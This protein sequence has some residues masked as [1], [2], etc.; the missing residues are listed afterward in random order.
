MK[1]V[2]IMPGVCVEKN[3]GV[4][5]YTMWK[6]V[7][8]EFEKR[9]I[10]FHTLDIYENWEELDWIICDNG[11]TTFEDYY[12]LERIWKRGQGKK[13]IYIAEEPEVVDIR[14]SLENIR[15]LLKIF[16]YITTWDLSIKD[17]RIF[18]L[19]IP[20][21]HFANIKMGKEF[22]DRK[23]MVN[24]SGNKSSDHPKELYGER[25]AFIE[26]CEKN[27]IDFAL[28]GTGWNLEER[29]SYK[30]CAKNKL[31]TY[32]DYKYAL[33][34]ENARDIP[35]YITE[36]IMDCFAG[37]I[38]P[39]YAGAKDISNIIPQKLYIDYFA[40]DSKE[41]L[42]K[43]LENISEEEY[44][45]KLSVTKKFIE[46]EGLYLFTAKGFVDNFINTFS[47]KPYIK[48]PENKLYLRVF[49]LN[50]LKKI[51]DSLK[52]KNISW[53]VKIYRKILGVKG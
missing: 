20:S 19:T 16:P 24:I 8:I 6:D 22:K 32:G 37:N 43:Y 50:R 41:E 52:L 44:N 27:S 9:N 10:E 45:E 23:F 17:S 28:Y 40:F 7:K 13:L 18:S 29:P 25:L 51:K 30:G 12:W 39:V 36:K 33:C 15:N 53:L 49:I 35:G 48:L 21:F 4:F 5:K 3:D 26:Y 11:Y 1:K 46:D 31:E 14:H 47:D 34:L 42:I 38:V 2:A